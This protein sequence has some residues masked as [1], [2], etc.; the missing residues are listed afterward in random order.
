MN[1]IFDSSGFMAQRMAE[2]F[3][4]PFVKGVDAE[5]GGGIL[6]GILK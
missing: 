1:F 5:S 3:S 2:R 4:P 6:K